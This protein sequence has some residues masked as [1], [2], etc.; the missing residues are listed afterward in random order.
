[1]ATPTITSVTPST[2]ITRGGYLVTIGGTDF[3]T[4]VDFSATPTTPNGAR[5]TVEF[6][7]RL[8]TDV[9]VV[10]STALTCIV[11]RGDL[12][13]A[14][15]TFAVDVV[16]TN[17]DEIAL[18]PS[19]TLVAGFTYN[20]PNLTD[21]TH[22]A[23]VVRVLMQRMKQQIVA[24]VALHT[25]TDF[26]LVT[27]DLTNRVEPAK[28]PVVVLVGPTLEPHTVTN[29]N[30]KILTIN[31]SPT[32]TDFTKHNRAKAVDLEFEV[33]LMSS[34][35][36][37]LLNLLHHAVMFVHRNGLLDGIP[38]DPSSPGLG[39]VEY[40]LMIVD[41]FSAADR[42]SRANVREASGT[43]RVEG[44]LLESGDLIEAAP[45]IDTTDL[46]TVPIT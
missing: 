24:N 22:L 27:G 30:A 18:P 12:A 25:H 19:A 41:E 43:W 4:N 2:G 11:P 33:R 32:P 35:K 8:A 38:I 10:S 45:V 5:M 14:L 39:T 44:V 3:D 7:G 42:P 28:L 20:R 1:M 40:G 37:E 15:N 23:N 9:R 17:L 21:E 34:S 13:D 16:V 31:G 29:Y 6:D 26:D 46:Q 36:K